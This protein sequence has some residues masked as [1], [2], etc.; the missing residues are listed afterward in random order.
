MTPSFGPGCPWHGLFERFGAPNVDWC[1]RAVCALIN[2][3][4]NA[5]SNLAYILPAAWLFR[6]ASEAGSAEGARVALAGLFMGAASFAYHATNNLATQYLDFFGMYV[7]A[8]YLIVLRLRRA[9][10]LASGPAPYWLFVAGLSALTPVL[11]AYGL[12]FQAVVAVLAFVLLG[13]ELVCRKKGVHGDGRL[14]AGA[15]AAFFIGACF[16]AADVSRFFC[17]PDSWLQGHALWH[18]CGGVGM[19]LLTLYHL[20]NR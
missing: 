15:A 18:C 2:E 5:W 8:A 9:Y 3:P 19:T 1:E 20:K 13:L 11:H 6:R 7:W 17:W 4:S 16:S 10:G 14:I 12:P